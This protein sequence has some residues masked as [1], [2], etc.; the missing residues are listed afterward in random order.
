MKKI[1]LFTSM[2]LFFV[3]AGAAN[4]EPKPIKLLLSPA[5]TISSADLMKHIVEKCPNVSITL[6]P[7][8]SDF[9]LEA[10]GWSGNYKFTVYQH[11]G[12]AVYSTTT[13]MLSNAVKD[14]CKYVNLPTSTT[15]VK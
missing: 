2:L 11:G 7:K 3:V 4:A 15:S 12:V 13:R 6:D 14:V 8:K 9:M 10:G 5:S 1:I